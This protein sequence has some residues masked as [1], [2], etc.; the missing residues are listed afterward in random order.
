MLEYSSL[1]IHKPINMQ[2]ASYSHATRT[3]TGSLI[4]SMIGSFLNLFMIDRWGRKK[5]MAK[6][7]I[8]N[9]K[10]VKK[11]ETNCSIRA[12]EK[13]IIDCFA[14]DL[15]QIYTTFC[16]VPWLSIG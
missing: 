11:K 14:W 3:I 15:P 8:F 13:E 7:Y 6:M 10:I 2:L 16:L 9:E 12:K 5:V 4:L 1:I